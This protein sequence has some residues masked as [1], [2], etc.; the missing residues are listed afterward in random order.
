VAQGALGGLLVL[1]GCAAPLAAGRFPEMTPAITWA[2]G[3]F[4]LATGVA[5][6]VVAARGRILGSALVPAAGMAV[7]Y[8]FVA[9][10]VYPAFEPRKSARPLAERLVALTAASP[11]R[12]VPV[13]AYALG[14]VPNALAF[15]S[16]G[17]YTE[18]TD[19]V[20]V[21]A[22]HLERAEQAWAVADGDKLGGLPEELRRRVTVVERTRLS[23]QPVLVLTNR[24][25]AGGTP[26]AQEGSRGDEADAGGHDG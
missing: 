11:G 10:A 9:T 20:G 24:P 13:V 22:R 6:L 26:L 18:E 14:N 16:Q 12:D 23:R 25:Y 19:D 1:V 17:L 4:I 7:L 15:Y 2:L 3:V 21:L 5:T 8:V